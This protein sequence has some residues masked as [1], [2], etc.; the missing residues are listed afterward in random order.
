MS[1]SHARV[2]VITGAAQGIGRE[3]AREL[4]SRGWSLALL[5]QQTID[6]SGYRD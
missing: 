5:D 6:V 2:A 1:G 3:T 4:D